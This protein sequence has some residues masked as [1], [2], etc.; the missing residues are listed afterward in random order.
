MISIEEAITI[1]KE[2][3]KPLTNHETKALKDCLG[4]TLAA[5]VFS[6]INMPPFRQS[7]MDGYAVY[8]H[9][10]NTYKIIDEVKA[11][12][13]HQPRLQSGEA[14]RIFTG[15]P[16]P[17]S[18][19]AIIIQEHVSI[20]NNTLTANNPITLNANIRPLGE[21]TKKDDVALKRGTKLTP[22][23]IGFL[24]SLGITEVMINKPTSIAL[25]VTG[26]ELAKAGKPLKYGQIYESNAIMLSSALNDLG[27]MNV[28]IF[29]VEDDYQSTYNVLQEAISNND[30]VLV[31]GGISVGDYDFVGKALLDLGVKQ[32]FYK[33]KQKPGKPLFFG[34]KD[35]TLVF[36]LPGNPASA[37]SC[38]YI[39]VYTALQRVSGNEHFELLKS[40][41]KS[42]SNFT[43]KGD[44]AQFL[45]AIYNND[46]VEILEGQN[47]SMIHTFALANALVYVPENL[48]EIAINDTVNVILL[49]IN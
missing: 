30:M 18:A 14:V 48:H 45:K 13:G 26:N 21:Q 47:S 33:V 6:P 2:H 12:D 37:L 16:V 41:A 10:S 5:D 34:K 32:L 39:Y 42:I 46:K 15:A 1:V 43:K 22:A 7:A 25:V 40:T 28:E 19:N 36:A 11:G 29:S 23:G 20:D 38:F 35:D 8:K 31:S 3:T 9:D 4:K 24:T 27:Y 49:P 17:N 44:R